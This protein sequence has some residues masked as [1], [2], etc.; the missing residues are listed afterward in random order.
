MQCAFKFILVHVINHDVLS[1]FLEVHLKLY[2][3]ALQII[4]YKQYFKQYY[5]LKRLLF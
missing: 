3:S 4:S 1:I 5:L 2:Y